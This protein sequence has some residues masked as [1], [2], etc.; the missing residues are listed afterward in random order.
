MIDLVSY[1]PSGSLGGRDVDRKCVMP[2]ARPFT[3]DVNDRSLARDSL[4]KQFANSIAGPNAARVD[5]HE[6]WRNAVFG[7]TQACAN[8]VDE[9]H[10][11]SVIH[12][13]QCVQPFGHNE[14]TV[15]RLA[16]RLT[17][18]LQCIERFVRKSFT[19]NRMENVVV[20]IDGPSANPN[21]V[22]QLFDELIVPFSP[23]A[24]L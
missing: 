18:L 19:R 11:L 21:D 16:D 3:N 6:L 8:A 24:F 20:A 7:F 2:A 12:C 4:E 14:Q 17:E 15:I 1:A 13:A 22:R 9:R 5:D 10:Q 23:N